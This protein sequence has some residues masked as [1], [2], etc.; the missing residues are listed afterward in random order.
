[1]QPNGNVIVD[2]I[3]RTA[4][5]GVTITG[6]AEHG[7]VTVIEAEP[8]EP[9]NEC[10]TCGQPGVFR[11]HVIRSLVDLPIVGHP[12]RLH[13]RLPRYRCTNKRCLQK[14]FRAGLA[15]A[16]DNSKTTDRVTRWILQR[17]CLDRMSVAAAAKSLGLGWDTTNALAL[18]AVQDL[19]YNDEHYLDGVKVIGVDE[20]RWSHNRRKWRDGYVTVI[21]DM[22]DHHD[23]DGNVIRPA[24]LLDVVPGRSAEALR[25]WLSNQSE[26][27]RDQVKIIS[28]DGFQGYAT[29]AGEVIP[30]ATQVMDPFHVV[31]LA[32]DKLTKCRTRLQLETTGRRGRRKDPLYR[33]RKTLLTTEHLLTDKQRGR[34]EELFDFDDDYAPLQET[35]TYY[36]QVISCY[37]NPN[38]QAAKKA[39]STL[40]DTLVD[41]KDAGI[42][43]IAQL[44]RT[45]NKRRK[46]IL[47]YFDHG[48]SNGPVEAINGR[49]EFLRGIALGFRNLDHY[50][51]RCLI[52]AANIR[53]KI[54]AL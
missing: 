29:A 47:A 40:I 17:L 24:R 31:R 46:D 18:A 41:I 11:D 9:I 32:G 15:C 10:P 27:F 51:L 26:Q 35:W 5:L 37:N 43:E 49:L 3:C 7:D 28:M 13:V 52:H 4:E 54:N 19:I 20:H 8:V 45:M 42:A 2:T 21:V 33:N 50:I 30:K 25:T 12:T 48:V 22:T 44:G 23:K 36:Q 16:P 6:A 39:M 34:L 14:I 1:M 38:K 53:H